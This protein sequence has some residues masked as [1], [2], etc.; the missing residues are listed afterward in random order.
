MYILEDE[1]NEIDY[2]LDDDLNIVEKHVSS[3]W[4]D[5]TYTRNVLVKE[6][7]YKFDF[8]AQDETSKKPAWLESEAFTLRRL[9][10]E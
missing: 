6:Y 8:F 7:G 5:D 1:S 9:V 4:F 2:L 3:S 10:K